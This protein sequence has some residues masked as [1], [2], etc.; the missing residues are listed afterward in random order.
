MIMELLVHN[1]I[2]DY[3]IYNCYSGAKY[4]E[5]RGFI[6]KKTIVIPNCFPDISVPIYRENK[7]TKRIITIG[8]FETQKDYL[9]AI[10]SIS[11]LNEKRTDFKFIIIGH[12]NL[13]KRIRTW[14]E[15]YHI[16]K[17]TNVYIAPNNVQEILKASDIYLST[18]LFEGTSNSLMEAMNWSIPIVATNVGDNN[19]LVVD[20]ENGFLTDI[21]DYNTIVRKLELLLD[22]YQLRLSMGIRGNRRLH[23]YSSEIFEQNYAKIINLNK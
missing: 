22:D 6:N 8:R 3:T 19:A 23:N 2:A 1:F 16:L 5:K 15:E 20:G 21:K 4:F 13:E 11:K 9:T 7:E 14:I 10:K 18:S 17:C 12:G